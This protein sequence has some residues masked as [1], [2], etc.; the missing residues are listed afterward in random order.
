MDSL[1]SRRRFAM[2]TAAA[3]GGIALFDAWKSVLADDKADP[4]HGFPVGAQSYSLRNFKVQEAVRHLYG[5]GVHYVEMFG[6]HFPVD[7]Q[8][9]ALADAKKM[10]SDAKIE[11]RAHGVHGFSKDHEANRKL[12]DFAKRAGFKVITADPTPDSFDSLD[13][14]VAEY[15][16]RIAIHNHGPEGR[17]NKI[18]DTAK[19]IK[20]HHEYI[21]ACVDTGHY[22]RSAEDPV[23][24]VRTFGNRVYAVHIKDD[25]EQKADTHNVVIGKGHLDVVGLFKAIKEVK[26]PAFGCLA[27]EYEAKPDNPVA[28]MQACFD[29]AKEAIAKVVG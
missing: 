5:M 29:V 3:A 6:A 16:V 26:F 25:A 28:D 15:D 24:A 8:G 18:E 12:F 19:A 23:K 7:L 14:L 20:G 17:Y 13:K 11:L 22:I 27:L 4:Y 1:L 21:G 9:E 10:L 2:A